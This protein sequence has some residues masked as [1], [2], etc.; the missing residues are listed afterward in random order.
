MF[1]EF[2][3]IFITIALSVSTALTS[4]NFPNYFPFAFIN[5]IIIKL[6]TFKYIYI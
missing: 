4:P 3:I 6:K 2:Y 1:K 5:F